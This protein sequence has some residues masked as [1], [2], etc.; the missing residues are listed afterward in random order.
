[1]DYLLIDSILCVD[2]LAQ[3]GNLLCN[4]LHKVGVKVDAHLQ[5]RYE[6]VVTCR[7]A[8]VVH[9]QTLLRLAECARLGRTLRH[10]HTLIRDDERHG[11]HRECSSRLRNK[12]VGVRDNRI[13]VLRVL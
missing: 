2:I 13:F 9:L 4:H 12:E 11:L 6:D 5:Q 8:A 7:V 10:E 1:M 3:L